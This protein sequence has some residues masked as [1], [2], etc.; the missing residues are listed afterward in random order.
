MGKRKHVHGGARHHRLDRIRRDREHL[1]KKLDQKNRHR[2]RKGKEMTTESFVEPVETKQVPLRMEDRRPPKELEDLELRC[3][4]EHDEQTY[5]NILNIFRESKTT[6]KV[7]I[8]TAKHPSKQTA[9]FA[10]SALVDLFPNSEFH[11]RG[12]YKI[13]DIAKEAREHG[14]THLLLVGQE[15]R[16]K[17]PDT[18]VVILLAK[19]AE[20]TGYFRL[21]SIKHSHKEIQNKGKSTPHYPELLLNNFSTKLGHAVGALFITLFPT[22][23]EFTGRQLVTLHNQ[24]D[25]IFVR[26]H[27]YV[28]E[29]LPA[30]K[31]EVYGDREGVGKQ[32]RLQEIGPQ[33]T[34]RLEALQRGIF[35]PHHAIMTS[36]SSTLSKPATEDCPAA[37]KKSETAQAARFKNFIL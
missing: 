1:A 16:K 14:F 12:D 24:R 33:F 32:A 37:V 10:A 26:R 34:M 18:L 4:G 13:Q 25:F 30:S 31:L 3:K 20:V 22:M 29:E 8:T 28:F 6:P 11:P 36:Q 15:A 2:Q 23:P 35:E 19:D 27:R 5:E 17:Q 9:T 7:V 21:T